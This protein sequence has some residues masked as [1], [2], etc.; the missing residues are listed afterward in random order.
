MEHFASKVKDLQSLTVVAVSSLLHVLYAVVLDTHLTIVSF[1]HYS[2][3][4]NIFKA[5]NKNTRKTC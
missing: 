1:W 3:Y 2:A 5:S 4:K